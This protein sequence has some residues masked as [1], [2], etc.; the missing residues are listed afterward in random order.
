[1][2]G[3]SIDAAT[4]ESVRNIVGDRGP[5]IVNLDSMHTHD[6][7]LE[8]L[9]LYSSFVPLGSYIVVSD[10]MIEEMP[11]GFYGDR[12]WDVGYNPKTAV[13]EFLKDNSDFEIDKSIAGKLVA[14][15]NHDG[16]LK[17]VK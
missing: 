16:Y 6:H 4:V 3:S 11:K 2:E 15:C 5:V 1:M 8:E 9:K 7:V 12:P 13:Y 17:R 14:T 10:T